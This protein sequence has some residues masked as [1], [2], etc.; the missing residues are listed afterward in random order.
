VVVVEEKVEN[1]SAGEKV[2]ER[3]SIIEQEA[4]ETKEDKILV[5]TVQEKVENESAGQV[6][7]ENR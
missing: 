3:E 7:A 5:V 6:V 2:A 1:E 4:D